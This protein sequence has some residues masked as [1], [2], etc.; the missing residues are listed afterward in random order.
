MYY[1][2]SAVPSA[3]S[4]LCSQA[5]RVPAHD[6]IDISIR[7]E[8]S[9]VRPS[10]LTHTLQTATPP[11]PSP[12]CRQPTPA[13]AGHASASMSNKAAYLLSA[14][15]HG[16]TADVRGVATASV[17]GG[18]L[19]LS[20]SRDG[21]GRLWHRPRP[22]PSQVSTFALATELT[23]HRGFVNAV[24]FWRHANNSLFAVTAGQD[25]SIR[26]HSIAHAGGAVAAAHDP[27]TVLTGHS[28]N[29]CAL[30]TGSSPSGERW[31]VSASWDKTAKVWREDGACVATL[32]GHEMAVWAVLVLPSGQVV[33]ASADKTIRLWD[34][35]RPQ[36]PLAVFMGHTDAVRG[37]ALLSSS[38]F[39][40]CGNDGTIS[41]YDFTGARDD[42]VNRPIQTLSGHTSF[43]YSLSPIPG[44]EGEL[45]SSGEDRSVR[46]WS[47]SG[48]VVQTIT[49]PAISVWS[50]ATL[51]DGDLVTATNDAVVRVF[52]RDP[53][54]KASAEEIQVRIPPLEMR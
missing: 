37:L 27:A 40:S 49:L 46:V 19:V 29:V 25:K 13:T 21:S 15:L 23:G 32:K 35:L 16:H 51:S 44:S 6:V 20:G 24:A 52:S 18:D 22:E 9:S 47:A 4:S 39:G 1:V 50:V 28:E 30:A 2:R 34:P 38:L 31:L 42:T 8:R 48:S 10:D 26:V 36:A 41:L 17:E 45:V 53:T 3:A 54:H 14:E 7:L 43:V 5:F 11:T 33:T 12:S